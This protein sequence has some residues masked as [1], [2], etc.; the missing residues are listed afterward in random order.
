MKLLHILFFC[1]VVVTAMQTSRFTT[2]SDVQAEKP[3]LF[4]RLRQWIESLWDKPAPKPIVETALGKTDDQDDGPYRNA[5]STISEDGLK[6]PEVGDE[7]THVSGG[8]DVFERPEEREAFQDAIEEGAGFLVREG[9]TQLTAPFESVPIIND[10]VEVS[11]VVIEQVVVERVVD[12]GTTG[13][14][15]SDGKQELVVEIEPVIAPEPA[16][17]TPEF[18]DAAPL[19]SPSTDPVDQLNE[20]I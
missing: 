13:E 5:L 20:T 1:V 17:I 8:G 2:T 7:G 10:V 16:P 14:G 4:G 19:A 9:P 18:I 11:P 3:G 6:E 12:D 15:E